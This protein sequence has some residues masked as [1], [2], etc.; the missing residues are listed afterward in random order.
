MKKVCS[1]VLAL[2]LLFGCFACDNGR[3]E[4]IYS[5]ATP[6]WGWAKWES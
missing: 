4:E 6:R 1:L 2:C 5:Q 3:Q